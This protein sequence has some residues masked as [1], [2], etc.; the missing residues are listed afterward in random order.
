MKVEAITIKEMPNHGDISSAK[1]ASLWLDQSAKHKLKF[2]PWKDYP[3][4]PKVSFA[5]SYNAT[6]ILLKYFVEENEIR[7]RNTSINGPVWQD[8]CVEFFISF[9]EGLHY[10]NIELNCLGV[11]LVGYGKSKADRLLLDPAL[12]GGIK[13]LSEIKSKSGKTISWELTS[14]LPLKLFKFTPIKALKHTSCRAN[15]YKCGDLLPD[16]HFLS[17]SDI[18]APAPDFHLAE[19]FG[20]LSFE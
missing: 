4:K 17:W 6:H 19:Y 10:Y 3:Y 16:P 13:S 18:K 2:V 7:A 20:R 14:F 12:I 1:E 8:S 9:D 11:A 5:I 15:F